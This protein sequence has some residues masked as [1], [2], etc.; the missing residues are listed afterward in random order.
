[1]PPRPQPAVRA[2]L[3]ASTDS[4]R[5]ILIVA[6]SALL[7]ILVAV[8]VWLLFLRNNQ[9]AA[10]VPADATAQVAATQSSI[11]ESPS[12]EAALVVTVKKGDQ[13]NVIRPP[14]SRS[15]EWTEVQFVS[16]KKVFPSGAM[17]TADLANW[18]GAKPD[19]A[20]ALL[21]MFAPGDD[22]SESDLR[23]YAQNLS[24]YMQHFGNSAQRADAQAELDRTNAALARLGAAPPPAPKPGSAPSAK[25]APAFDVQTAMA[26]ARLA[27]ED[28][29]YAQA[30]AQLRR[31][32]QV[33]PNYAE[34][35]EL[36]ERVQR[37]KQL[38][39]AR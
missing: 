15:Q 10:R 19:V 30:E 33:R 29:E 27:W 26:K 18:T 4:N 23:T 8:L 17:H 14:R 21:Q 13:V 36:L 32:L 6:G 39:S 9:N 2:A 24:G 5:L 16:G 37:A 7:L 3:P 34:A 31:V 1:M 12:E 38:E 28:G 25:P 22:A 20:L 11:F 35:R